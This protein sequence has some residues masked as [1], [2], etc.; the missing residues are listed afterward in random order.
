MIRHI[1][2]F[3]LLLILQVLVFNRIQFSGY[4]NPSVYLFFII[5]MPLNTPA[6]LR[7]LSG[8]TLGFL[9]DIFSQSPG[10]HTSSSVLISYLQPYIVRTFQTT[11]VDFNKPSDASYLGFRWFM[12][13]S[14]VLILI[15]QS[16]YFFLEVFG[17]N[18]FFQ[19]FL[20]IIISS[21]ATFSIILLIQLILFKKR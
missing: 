4:I 2:S 9:V 5:V 19:T 10:L 15:H 11:E 7:L 1:V 16:A 12:S 13:Q 20:R 8:F 3:I 14:V 6:W 21:F 17:L 18:N